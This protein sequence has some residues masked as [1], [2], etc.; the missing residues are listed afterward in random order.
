[1]IENGE[2]FGGSDG[3]NYLTFT[4]ISRMTPEAYIGNICVILTCLLKR[5]GILNAVSL[6]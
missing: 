6:K 5:T 4:I 2:L 3:K 1:M